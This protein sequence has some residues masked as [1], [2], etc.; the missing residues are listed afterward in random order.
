LFVAVMQRYHELLSSKARSSTSKS[1]LRDRLQ[2]EED[3]GQK[4]KARLNAAQQ[5]R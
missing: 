2:A 3:L 1:G 5:K 4:I